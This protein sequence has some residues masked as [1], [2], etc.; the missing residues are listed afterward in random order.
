MV[1]LAS[2]YILSDSAQLVFVGALRGSGDTRWV[3]RVSVGLHWA[4][5][6]IAFLLIKVV[7]ADPVLVWWVF[8]VAIIIMGIAMFLRFKGG[9]WQRNRIIDDVPKV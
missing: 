1:R 5:A 8:I 4:L 9:K 6:L 3:M 2:L 7:K